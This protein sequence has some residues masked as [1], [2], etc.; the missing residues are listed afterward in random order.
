MLQ[1]GEM[2]LV[3][4]V[5][6]ALA[7]VMVVFSTSSFAMD[8][9]LTHFRLPN[10]LAVFVKEDHSRKVVFNVSENGNRNGILL[11]ESLGR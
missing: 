6:F 5:R 9:D 4:L 3:T 1:F 11:V 8:G 7:A 10:G 2:N